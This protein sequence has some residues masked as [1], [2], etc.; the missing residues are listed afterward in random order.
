MPANSFSSASTI[1]KGLAALAPLLLLGACAQPQESAIRYDTSREN[2]Q[3]DAESHAMGRSPRIASQINLGFGG[4]GEA[5]QEPRAAAAESGEAEQGQTD[6]P[7]STQAPPRPLAEPRSFLG[8]VPC[9]P[10]MGCE[11]SRFLVTFAPSGEWR[12][13]TTLLENNQQTQSL[14][15]QGCWDVIGDAPLRIALVHVGQDTAKADLSFV[16]DNTLRVHALNG[17]Q[18]M[19]EHRLTRQADIDPIDE[20][21]DRP[22]LN[23]P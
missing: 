12:A 1:I 2:T 17:V 21:K 3:L 5:G 7:V 9:S 16:N 23:C 15:D 8:T 19:L 22:V 4:A 20:L 13:R 10:G 14:A 11:A 6:E 18:P